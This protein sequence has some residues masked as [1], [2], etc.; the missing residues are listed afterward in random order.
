MSFG[1]AV[2]LCPRPVGKIFGLDMPPSSHM[3]YLARIVGTRDITLACG[4]M[5]TEGDARRQWLVA[6]FASDCADVVA[7]LAGGF[8]GYLPKRTT[9]LLTAAAVAPMVRGAIALRGQMQPVPDGVGAR[10][11]R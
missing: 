2:W 1:V 5:L 4:L 11:G 7:A 9:V 3:P 10:S 6:G 8:G